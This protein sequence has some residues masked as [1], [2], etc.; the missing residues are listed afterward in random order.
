MTV[1]FAVGCKESGADSDIPVTITVEN[2][3]IVAVADGSSTEIT[4]TVSPATTDFTYGNG[5][6]NA[7]LCYAVT[8]SATKEVYMDSVKAEGEGRYSARI[9]NRDLSDAPFRIDVRIFI[10][11]S[12]DRTY[13]S[14]VFCVQNTEA[15]TGISSVGFLKSNNPQLDEDIYCTYD[16][17]TSTFL[18]RTSELVDVSALV[19]TFIAMGDVTV[20][21]TKQQSGV[22]PNDFTHDVTYVVENGG[23]RIEYTVR[24]VNFTGL[25]VMYIN[26]TTGMRPIGSDITSKEEWKEATIRIDGN[27][28]WDD[29]PETKMQ[30]RGRGNI[31]W[32]WDKK[33]FNMKFDKRT[34]ML[35]MPEHKRWVMLANYCD[36]TMVRNSTAFYASGL[37]S[38]A[39]APRSQYVELYYNGEYTGTYQLTEQVRVDENR[40]NVHE[41]QPEDTDITGGYLVEMDF[42][43][44]ESPRKWSPMVPSKYGV[45]STW[46]IV[47]S[48][49]DDDLTDAQFDYIRNYIGDFERAVMDPNLRTDPE[50][51]YKNYI[52]P[53]SFIDY[54]LLYEVC[55]N[56][57]IL[58]PGSVYLHKDRGGK[59]VA[60]PI[61]DF[62][63]GTFN[64]TYFE[65]QPAAYSLYVKDAIWMHYLFED[66][67]MRDLAKARWRELRPAFLTLPDFV[68]RC[69]SQ[70]LYAVEENYSRWPMTVNDNGDAYFS[71]AQAVEFMKTVIER[72]IAII[73]DCMATW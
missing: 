69:S 48:P 62:D 16:D 12:D 67:E 71:Y 32:G 15:T 53:L 28:V 47:K 72:R 66:E 38:L 55:I 39:W 27:G 73:D 29:L 54:W 40:V 1:L 3:G 13:M 61:W 21:G 43:W 33:P 41:L 58:N 68:D 34:S 60:G 35:G 65:A 6:Y 59:L 57:E 19:A 23:E 37:T 70:L 44:D 36:R 52:D 51:G 26:S 20:K 64:F 30:L 50:R 14:D 11:T 42:H 10:T 4:F 24:V 9:V 46:Y 63:Y 18:V 49:D 56:H 25:P 8:H 7:R 17:A 2:S 31:T 22:T 45:S 5:I